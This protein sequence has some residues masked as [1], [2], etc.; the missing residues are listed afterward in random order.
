MLNNA[1]KYSKKHK[2]V[3]ISASKFK[4][5]MI[6]I[7][8]KDEGVGISENNQTKLFRID[9]KVYYTGERKVKREVEWD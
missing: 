8:V 3:S 7:C 5:G 1:V 4:A 9:Q 2:S 6:E